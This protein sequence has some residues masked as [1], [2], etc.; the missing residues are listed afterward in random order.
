MFKKFFNIIVSVI[1]AL[2]VCTGVVFAD[3]SNVYAAESIK[4]HAPDTEAL[5]TMV[6]HN[7]DLKRM[8]VQSTK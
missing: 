2:S 6:E 3:S 5:I 8:L 1:I 7:A 4:K